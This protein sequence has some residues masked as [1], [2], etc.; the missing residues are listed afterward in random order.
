MANLSSPD[1][2]GIRD[3]PPCEH[4][5]LFPVAPREPTL[6]TSGGQA[7]AS[8]SM[9]IQTRSGTF[10]VVWP[11]TESMDIQMSVAV[12]FKIK[13]QTACIY[14]PLGTSNSLKPY[15]LQL[16][17]FLCPWG[18]SRQEY[19]SEIAIL[20]SRESSQARDGAQVSRI[21]GRFLTVSALNIR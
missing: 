4:K 1:S 20:F 7:I 6:E 5:P 9:D 21:A 19:W 15:G 14:Q 12:Q 11:Q 8:E 16:S 10:R 3:T 2:A 13:Y 18:F 17:R